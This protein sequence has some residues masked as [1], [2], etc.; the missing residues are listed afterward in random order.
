[1]TKIIGYGSFDDFNR[2]ARAVRTVEGGDRINRVSRAVHPYGGED[3]SV[4]GVWNNEGTLDCPAFGIMLKSG[5]QIT[6]SGIVIRARQPTV[7]GCQDN[8]VI[9]DSEGVD[10]G[11]GGA[12][13]GMGPWGPGTFI[14]A[15]DSGDGI[16][17]TGERWGPRSGTWLLKKSTYGFIILDVYDSTNHYAL[18]T[19]EPMLSFYGKNLG[20]AI[21]KNGHGDINIYFGAANAL[22]DTSVTVD[23]ESIFGGIAANAMVWCSIVPNSSPVAGETITPSWMA[24]QTDTCP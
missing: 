22:A 6:S 16:P 19:S 10:H 21:A 5:I 14:A 2:V 18:V 11:K 20:S 12:A 13:Q 7:Y 4:I 3:T 1:M 17:A 9:A 15:Y 23:T 24:I 8:F